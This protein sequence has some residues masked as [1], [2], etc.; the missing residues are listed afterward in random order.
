MNILSD[1]MENSLTA[2][3]N[4]ELGN[5]D[6]P[7]QILKFANYTQKE[8]EIEFSVYINFLEPWIPINITFELNILYDDDIETK[9]IS[10]ILKNEIIKTESAEYFC[11]FSTLNDTDKIISVSL[12]LDPKTMLFEN[13]ENIQGIYFDEKAEYDSQ[14]LTEIENI[15][16]FGKIKNAQIEFPIKK[17]SLRIKGDIT[18]KYL[19]EKNQEIVFMQF[20]TN[21]KF[22]IYKCK[23]DSQYILDCDTSNHSINT[24]I[25]DIHLSTSI[26]SSIFFSIELNN[27]KNNTTAIQIPKPQKKKK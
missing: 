11:N 1:R 16:K 14:N 18:P 2:R 13:T 20:L 7:I 12:T 6:S 5:K 22:E 23:L 25:K 8:K 21:D 24:T 9:N 19:L 3:I 10:C 17:N 26:N 27:W 15:T 4:Q